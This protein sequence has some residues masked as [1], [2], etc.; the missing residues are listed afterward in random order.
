VVILFVLGYIFYNDDLEGRRMNAGLI[1]AVSVL[2]GGVIGYFTGHLEVWGGIGI[3]IGLLGMAYIQMNK[4]SKKKMTLCDTQQVQSIKR[5]KDI[6]IN[7]DS[8]LI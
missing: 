7:L 1:M 4:K 6:Q 8:S 5:T 3:V 2:I